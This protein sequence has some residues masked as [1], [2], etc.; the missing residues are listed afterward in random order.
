MITAAESA[1]GKPQERAPH[2]KPPGAEVA[3]CQ[4][5]GGTA[6]A[7]PGSVPAGSVRVP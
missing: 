3:G 5:P 4:L 1:G 2:V 6:A 7:V